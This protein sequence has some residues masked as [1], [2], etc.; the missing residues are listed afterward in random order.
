MVTGVRAR[1][2]FIY[3][4]S[5]PGCVCDFRH[6]SS[7]RRPSSVDS[8]WCRLSLR[9]LLTACD[10]PPDGLSGPPHLTEPT[11]G[12]KGHRGLCDWRG[13]PPR[14]VNHS[15]EKSS[16]TCELSQQRAVFFF[17][18]FPKAAP[19]QRHRVIKLLLPPGFPV[20]RLM[21]HLTH[22]GKAPAQQN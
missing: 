20:C 10:S 15:R 6:G 8:L 2:T 18:F 1:L 12:S 19:Q 3:A 14:G 11:A 4:D 5:H 17:S 9:A 16:C 21:I 7:I 22:T 13:P